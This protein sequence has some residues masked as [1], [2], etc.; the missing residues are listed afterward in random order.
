MRQRIFSTLSLF[1]IIVLGLSFWGVAAG[2]WLLI[3]LTLLT[4]Y[5]FYKLLEK[6]GYKSFPQVG[7]LFGA[8]ILV[9][10]WYGSTWTSLTAI[11]T[12]IAILALTVCTL[13][14]ISLLKPWRTK[15]SRRIIPTFFGVIYIPFMLQFYIQ[16]IRIFANLHM[17][18]EGLLL[19]IW[20]IVVAKITDVGGLLVGSSIGKHKLAPAISPQKTWEGAIGGV[21]ISILFGVI[22]FSFL[23]KY[24]PQNFTI[25]KAAIVA[26][27]I[28]IISIASDLVESLIKRKAKS[29]DSGKMI[30]GIGGAFD[31]MDSLILTAPVGY[32][33]FKL[34][35]F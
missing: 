8:I 4:Q 1:F 12:S 11:D 3:A 22:S 19:T 34:T 16:L 25:L 6:A 5:E 29:K 17:T 18:L 13:S 33:Y 9:S 32:Y 20:L 14:I 24:L 15:S 35:L 28:S 21:L 2:I 10:A 30:P 31:L 27:I 23:H 7:L 26:I